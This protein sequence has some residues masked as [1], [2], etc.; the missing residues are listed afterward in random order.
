[1]VAGQRDAKFRN[2]AERL[3]QA[4]GSNAELAV[5]EGAGHTVHLEQP[6]AFLGVLRTWLARTA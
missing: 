3:G 5:I 2:L 4:I 6:D 1:V